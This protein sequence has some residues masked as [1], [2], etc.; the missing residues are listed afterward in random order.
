[1]ESDSSDLN[2]LFGLEIADVGF[3]AVHRTRGY[4]IGA[5]FVSLAVL[6]LTGY[7]AFYEHRIALWGAA[8]LQLTAMVLT[9]QAKTQFDGDMP[10][11]ALEVNNREPAPATSGTA[12]AYCIVSATLMAM[13]T[14]VLVF[15]AV[16][17]DPGRTSMAVFGAGLP[18]KLLL[19]LHVFLAC[20][21]SL[22]I[23]SRFSYNMSVFAA[24]LFLTHGKSPPVELRIPAMALLTGSIA[25]DLASGFSNGHE[26][27]FGGACI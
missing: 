26:I 19:G 25:V 12:E 5:C 3:A 22:S 10:N 20:V 4:L 6:A 23:P 7:L 15:R 18:L 21:A 2:K 17:S 24:V 11:L 14:A 13:D 27:I 9:C 8:A 16:R 1:V